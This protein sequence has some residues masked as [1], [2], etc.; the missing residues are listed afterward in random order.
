MHPYCKEISVVIHGDGSVSVK[1]DGRGIPVE[2]HP[3]YSRPAHQRS[4]ALVYKLTRRGIRHAMQA[5]RLT[6]D[7][8]EGMAS[9]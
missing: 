2:I 1:D 8:V 3:Q 9:E 6:F 4:F 7:C 5:F